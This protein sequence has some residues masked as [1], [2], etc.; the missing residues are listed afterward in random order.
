[1][2]KVVIIDENGGRET[3]YM[4]DNEKT[5]EEKKAKHE[6]FKDRLT[7]AYLV[8]GTITLAVGLYIT[9]R[10]QKP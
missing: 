3:G 1:M 8:F 9:L 5:A 10:R 2:K 7:I 6:R 4:S